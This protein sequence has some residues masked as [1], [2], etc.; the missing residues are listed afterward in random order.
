M[1]KVGLQ[2]REDGKWIMIIFD[3]PQNHKKSRNLLRSILKNLGYEMFQHSVWITPYD[4]AEKTEE[5]L[6]WYSFEKYVRMFLIE[7]M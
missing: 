4:V 5:L 1:E 3:I 6:Q 7:K 2:K